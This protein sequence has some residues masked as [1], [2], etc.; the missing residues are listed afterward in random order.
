MP[1]T[2]TRACMSSKWIASSSR[3][4]PTAISLP[5]KVLLFVLVD[6]WSLLL[7]AIAGAYA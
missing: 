7:R 1:H 2:T 5:L 6:G 3:L 4:P